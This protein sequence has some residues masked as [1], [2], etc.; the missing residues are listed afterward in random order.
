MKNL[1][2]NSRFRINL[3]E[4][5]AIVLV[6]IYAFAIYVEIVYFNLQDKEYECPYCEY[7]GQETVLRK[8]IEGPHTH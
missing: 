5:I 3:Y 1:I 7:E 2:K 8:V 4:F 6:I